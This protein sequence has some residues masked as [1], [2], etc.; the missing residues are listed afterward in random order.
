MRYARGDQWLSAVMVSVAALLA[1]CAASRSSVPDD[2]GVDAAAERLD[3]GLDESVGTADGGCVQQLSVPSDCRVDWARAIGTDEWFVLPYA[4]R[5]RDDGSSLV[6]LTP[7]GGRLLIDGFELDTA[8]SRALLALDPSGRVAWALPRQ[9]ELLW[10]YDDVVIT[11]RGFPYA[12]ERR[13]AMDGVLI[14]EEAPPEGA[15]WNGIARSACASSCTTREVRTLFWQDRLDLGALGVVSGRYGFS[16]VM[17]E[18]DV[19]AW[20]WSTPLDSVFN[21]VVILPSS[22]I[23]PEGSITLAIWPDTFDRPSPLCLAGAPCISFPN[24]LVVRLSPGGT[25]DFTEV[26]HVTRALLGTDDGFVMSPDPALTRIDAAGNRV[27]HNDQLGQAPRMLA[28]DARTGEIW[29]AFQIP[30]EPVDLAGTTIVGCTIGVE[31]S[32][33]VMLDPNTGEVTRT[34]AAI[35]ARVV[36]MESHPD[37]GVIVQ[38]FTVERPTVQALCGETLRRDDDPRG[39][40][41]VVIAHLE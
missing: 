12:L 8:G 39:P 14:S 4:V 21:P 22:G 9:A 15:R 35:R 25:P 23:T 19:P 6:S 10:T 20:H 18:D 3:E 1:G 29:A 38:L 26:V 32:V 13:R 17:Y 2:A 33:I 30:R 16:V 27:W 41:D 37:G 5:V 11:A 40:I 36:A 34:K 31:T 24:S 7:I 28:T